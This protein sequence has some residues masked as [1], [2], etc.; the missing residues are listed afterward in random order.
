MNLSKTFLLAVLTAPAALVGMEDSSRATE[1]QSQECAP[2]LLNTLLPFTRKKA[3]SPLFQTLFFSAAKKLAVPPHTL[4]PILFSA[5]LPYCIGIC[6]PI[7]FMPTKIIINESFI[8]EHT[9][10]I[11]HGIRMA[12]I[13]HEVAH[14]LDR[15][16][17]M[18]TFIKEVMHVLGTW[19]A[20]GA[21]GYIKECETFADSQAV[22]N[23]EC[24]QCA[25]E[26]ASYRVDE[27]GTLKERGYLDYHQILKL[28]EKTYGTEAQCP[29]H[30]ER[31]L[32][33]D[34]LMN[35]DDTSPT[36]C[37][38]KASRIVEQ[39]IVDGKLEI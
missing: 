15:E 36:E 29:F 9:G 21:G 37:L 25:R 30:K 20:Y 39:K 34:S 27:H 5:T 23:L 33:F 14:A 31:R 13:F 18:S 2:S 28:A 4:C 16:R 24:F 12:T 6:V 32:A 38:E 35:Q 19:K 1:K 11:V 22:I 17:L 8:A 10:T 26:F 7:P 3:A